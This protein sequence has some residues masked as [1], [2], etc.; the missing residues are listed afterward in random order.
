MLNIS[1]T[2]PRR[3]EKHRETRKLKR[4]SFRTVCSFHSLIPRKKSVESP[5]RSSLNFYK[6]IFVS[7]SSASYM[8]LGGGGGKKQQRQGSF[9]QKVDLLHEVTQSYL[10]YRQ[11]AIDSIPRS[12]RHAPLPATKQKS[13]YPIDDRQKIRPCLEIENQA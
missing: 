10:N 5:V 8:I 12:T 11:F 2:T 9:K 7:Y 3:G 6:K 1:R 13:R 4:P